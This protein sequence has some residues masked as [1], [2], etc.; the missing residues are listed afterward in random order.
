MLCRH[1]EQAT[2][3]RPRKL[4]WTCF[5]TPGVRDLYPATSKFGRRGPGNFFGKAQLPPFPTQA[6]PGSPEK[7][8][9]LEQRANA[10]QQLFHPLDAISPLA[11]ALSQ[12]G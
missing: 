7:I 3:S 4:C 5:Y 2:I 8:A 1:C 10:R 6:M 12:A 11:A 9:L